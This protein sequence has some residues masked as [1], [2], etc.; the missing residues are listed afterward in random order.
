VT[1]GDTPA[2]PL[3]PEEAEVAR[4]LAEAAGPEPVPASVAARLDEV[5]DELVSERAAAGDSGDLRV[6]R[7]RRWPRVLLAAAAVLVVGYA[8]GGVVGDGSLSGGQA[9][10]GAAEDSVA[11]GSAES[12][13][14]EGGAG[15]RHRNGALSQAGPTHGQADGS[16]ADLDGASAEFRT[17]VRLRSVQLD[18]GVRRALAVLA[19]RPSASTDQPSGSRCDA[20]P[21]GPSEESLLVRYDGRRAVLV[22]READDGLVEATV[23]TCVGAVLD[24]TVL[25]P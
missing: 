25:D 16:T 9:D 6:A 14:S 17:P 4:I 10:S 2:G 12:Q 19:L 20:P 13:G 18:A 3:T 5:L 11:A 22:T 23:Y 21:L 1:E 8:V 24:G 15:R 7:S